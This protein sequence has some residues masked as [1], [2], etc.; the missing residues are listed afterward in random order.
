MKAKNDESL[1]ALFFGVGRLLKSGWGQDKCLLPSFLHLET[2]RFIEE[3]GDPT[4]STL[5][6][7]LK[8]AAPTATALVN[9]LV[10]DGIVIRQPDSHD[11]RY[12]RLALS[13]EGKEMLTRTSK[14]REKAFDKLVAS[15]SATDR[16]HLRRILTTIITDTRS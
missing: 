16:T 6:G 9:S 11:R 10:K 12:V 8:V 13:K 2:L 7:Y 3:D 5:A 15:L 1:M 4:M 14:N